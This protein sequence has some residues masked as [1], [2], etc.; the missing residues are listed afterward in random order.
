MEKQFEQSMEG[1]QCHLGQSI[2]ADFF[3][4]YEIWR[5]IVYFHQSIGVHMSFRPSAK[6]VLNGLYDQWIPSIDGL[7]HWECLL[8][9]FRYQIHGLNQP[10]NSMILSAF[11]EKF[12]FSFF[13]EKKVRENKK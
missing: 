4:F 8:C 1:I 13:Y 6:R 2:E 3:G 9:L 10:W 7:G 11:H 5:K 12:T